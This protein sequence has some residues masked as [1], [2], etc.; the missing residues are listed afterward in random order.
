MAIGAG[1]QALTDSEIQIK[2]NIM[3]SQVSQIT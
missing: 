3:V 2:Q 1:F